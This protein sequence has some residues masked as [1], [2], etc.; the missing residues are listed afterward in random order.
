MEPSAI[1][2]RIRCLRI[3]VKAIAHPQGIGV[4]VRPHRIELH[5]STRG[6]SAGLA[7]TAV[8]SFGH[9]SSQIH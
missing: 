8:H 6:G 1:S 7:R 2:S 9:P 4:A 3:V 5:G